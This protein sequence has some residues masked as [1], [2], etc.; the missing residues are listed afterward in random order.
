MVERLTEWTQTDVTGREDL[1]AVV[2]AY[3]R[4]LVHS[5]RVLV[6]MSRLNLD[7]RLARISESQTALLIQVVQNTLAA[8]ARAGSR[9]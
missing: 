6:A 5:E 7:E 1:R 2:A 4:S 3:E 8:P 9:S